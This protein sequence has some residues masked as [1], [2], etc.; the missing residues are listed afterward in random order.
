[1]R[2]L[3]TAALAVMV[4]TLSARAAAQAPTVAVSREADTGAAGILVHNRISAEAVLG[5]EIPWTKENSSKPIEKAGKQIVRCF[6][7]D[8]TEIIEFRRHE[9]SVTNTVQEFR[10]F[11]RANVASDQL[12]DSQVVCHLTDQEHFKTVRGI[13]LGM[14]IGDLT[15][16]FGSLYRGGVRGSDTVVK[17]T[18]ES[19]LSPFL[20]HYREQFYYGNY[21]FRHGRLIEA[22]FGFALR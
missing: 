6:N 13:T 19:N 15:A 10:I 11:L 18:I 8:K 5:I 21:Y 17:Y 22:E 20:R 7:A 1:M 2:F 14:S 9:G 3:F 4:V 12:P 16:R